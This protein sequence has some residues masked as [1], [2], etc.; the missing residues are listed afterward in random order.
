MGTPASAVFWNIPADKKWY[1]SFHDGGYGGPTVAAPY[2]IAVQLKTPHILTH[3]TVTTSQ[4]VPTRDPKAWAIQGSNTGKAN[5]WTDIYR[6]KATD[7]K[8]SPFRVYPR[9]ETTLY[10]S[11]TS[12]KMAKAV[13]A[14]DLKKLTK[15]LGD[16]VIKKADFVRPG[17]AYTWFRFAC[18]SC[19][20]ANTTHVANPNRPPGFALGQLEFFGISTVKSAATTKTVTKIDDTKVAIKKA[21]P[22]I[23][24]P[25][26]VDAKVLAS[27]PA[28]GKGK[29]R[30]VISLDGVWD[31]EQ[32][33]VK[34]APAKFTH[35]ISVPGLVDMAK[36]GFPQVGVN[37]GRRQAFWY[38]KKFKVAGPISDLA[39]LKVHKAKFGTRVLLNGKL[40]GEHLPN[41]TPGLF[42][43]R[44]A[45]R[46]GDN[47]LLIRVG[48]SPGS[49]PKPVQWG[50]DDE[51]RRYFSGI[52]DS[53]ELILTGAP[54]ILRVQAVP[55]IDSK[56]VTVHAW[57][58]GAK[59]A[60][61]TRLHLT[62]REVS[63]GKVAGEGDCVIKSAGGPERTGLATLRVKGVRLWSPEDPFLYE[64]EAR[65]EAD[66]LKARF[67]MRHFTFDRK[68]GHALLNGKTYFMRGSNVSLYRFFED[69]QRGDKPWRE[70]WV[71]RKFKAYKDMHWNTLRFSICFPPEK[72]YEIADE[73][74]MLIQDEFPIWKMQPGHGEFDSKELAREYTE[75]MQERWNHPCVVIWDACN[76]TP[77]PETGKA[78][79]MV[80]GL[81][82][83]DRPWDNGWSP[84]DRPGDVYEAHEY[85]YK[86]PLFRLK[87][88]G[89][90]PNV[91]RGNAIRNKGKNPA[92][93]NE[94]GWLWLNRDGS[95]TTLT[96]KL[97]AGML[98]NATPAQRLRL[99]AKLLAA[100]TEFWRHS[101]QAAGL[102]HFSC[103]AYSR[104]GGQ[105]SD[106]WADLE[107]LK[108]D[109]EFYK[110]VRDAFAPVGIMLDAYEEEYKAGADRKFPVSVINDLY[111]AWEGTVRLRILRDGKTV[112]EKVLPCKV[113]ASGGTRLSFTVRI[114]AEL[115]GYQLEAALVKRGN[116]PV[117]SVRDFK[118]VT[119]VK[120]R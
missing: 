39:V 102:L 58:R 16:K 61:S 62:V 25:T 40:L 119:K 3:F 77:S 51:K 73:A 66:V 56:T 78:I 1:V 13:S 44:S 46:V 10:T 75:W 64:V 33:G 116:R 113:P 71:R 120:T 96:S 100:E 42:D 99:Y 63:T 34:A 86:D 5:G 7:R 111:D 110:Y 48:A 43:A 27:L 17:K 45:L 57:L 23:V 14:R 83:S 98:P 87:Y 106:H 38:R 91:P 53:V 26:V 12:A 22:K 11:F 112:A 72:W 95:P 94:Y 88:L 65:G 92:I 104:P 30:R 49:V 29:L 4:D 54:H 89:R 107:K 19:F 8:S 50:Y 52:F 18:T 115:V 97:Y 37:S 81:D 59:N 85:H 36:P 6:C 90:V 79:R 55:H 47:E 67:G 114:P 9:S 21:A 80:R 2:F 76:E 101:R 118:A 93:I 117:R 105:T 84:P 60:K 68:S 74:G 82:F 24:L 41:F 31:I 103:L 70:E 28:P 32:G 15:K 69:P 109:P 35:T 108:W 20:N